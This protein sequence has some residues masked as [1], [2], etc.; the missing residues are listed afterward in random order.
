MACSNRTG[1]LIN[2]EG[3]LDFS[4]QSIDGWTTKDP[5]GGQATGSNPTDR[6]KSGTKG[7]ILTETHGLPISLV[8]TGANVHDKTQAEPLLSAMPFLPPAA[9]D[10][11]ELH[12]CADKA[13][14]SADVGATIGLLGYQD[15]IK[16]RGQEQ[17]ARQ[18]QRVIGRVGGS[19]NGRIHG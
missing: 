9:V 2:I 8:V 18:Y 17:D 14:D 4:F 5:L 15:H 11:H 13:Y 6:G 10:D 19:A 3:Q 16:S 12:F 1:G 7:H